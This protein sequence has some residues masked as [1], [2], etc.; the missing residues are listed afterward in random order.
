VTVL[1]VETSGLLTAML[2]FHFLFPLPLQMK[3]LKEKIRVAVENAESPLNAT[4]AAAMPGVREDFAMT[5]HAVN[6]MEAKILQALS[7]QK[8]DSQ[9]T[10]VATR[11]LQEAYARSE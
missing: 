9:A 1:S 6:V 8:R 3:A 7:D 5:R 2:G 4:V 11:A 10:Q